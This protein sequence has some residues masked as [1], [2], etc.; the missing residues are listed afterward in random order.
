MNSYILEENE[1]YSW[2]CTPDYALID[3]PAKRF[4]VV[5]P[6][7]DNNCIPNMIFDAAL[8]DYAAV[9]LSAKSGEFEASFEEEGK[10]R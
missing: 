2:Y 5:D 6:Q 7:G 8:A 9:V 4:T 3:T 1:E 10:T